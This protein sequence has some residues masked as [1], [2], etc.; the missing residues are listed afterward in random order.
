VSD[1][2]SQLREA[3]ARR[4]GAG[5]LDLGRLSFVVPSSMPAGAVSFAPVASGISVSASP[6][7]RNQR[8]ND[9]TP[10]VRLARAIA[11]ASGKGGV[12]KSNLAVNLAVA[13]SQLGQKV[14]LLDADLGL[15]N[16]DVLCNL[17]PRLT[18]EQVV[19]GSC[20]LA[21][22]MLLAPGGFRLIPGASGVTRMADLSVAR[23]HALLEQLQALERVV[24]VLLVDCGAG[25]NAN[26]LGFACA[27]G[28]VLVVTTPE[29]TAITDGYG[30][31]KSLVRQAPEVTVQVVVNMVASEAEGR[32]VFERINRVSQTFLNRSLEYVGSIPAD[33]LVSQA[34]RQR[35]P[36][37]LSAPDG[38]A[39]AA[40]RRLATRLLPDHVTLRDERAILADVSTPKPLGFFGRMAE[41]LG[42]V[43]DVD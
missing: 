10:T 39:T 30:M 6:L 15:A 43:E 20:R 17:A 31:I 25:I 18:L 37:M 41:W 29:P 26:V 16:A 3:V 19:N 14:S 12:G 5:A 24:D 35:M 34:V 28:T 32:Q 40:I 27:A 1:Q 2:A 7:K 8:V 11:V 13:M 22:A 9:P 33:A 21:D 42:I 23:R 38:A 4:S 36:V